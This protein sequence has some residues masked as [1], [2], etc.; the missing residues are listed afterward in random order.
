[1]KSIKIVGK[2]KKNYR[3]TRMSEINDPTLKSSIDEIIA[4]EVAKFCIGHK[5]GLE[6]CLSE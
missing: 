2:K 3:C 1:M 4:E 5:E 6:I